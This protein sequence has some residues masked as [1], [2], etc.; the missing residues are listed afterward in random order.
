MG[1]NAKSSELLNVQ[2]N[3]SKLLTNTNNNL[4]K[5][6]ININNGLVNKID[7]IDN[8][9]NECT[10]E[11][12]Y[13]TLVTHT[14]VKGPWE[15]GGIKVIAHN[16]NH[17]PSHPANGFVIEYLGRKVVLSGD[18]SYGGVDIELTDEEIKQNKHF[19]ILEEVGKNCDLL[20]H[21]AQSYNG[22]QAVI[23]NI[24]QQASV[25]YTVDSE[26]YNRIQSQASVLED[27]FSYHTSPKQV[28][29]VARLLGAKSL[30][31]NHLVPFPPSSMLEVGLFDNPVK[32]EYTGNYIK[33]EDFGSLIRLEGNS[34]SEPIN[35]DKLKPGLNTQNRPQASDL[36]KNAMDVAIIGKSGPLIGAGD[37]SLSCTVVIAG[38][39]AL[40]ID[41]GSGSLTNTT[42]P[43]TSLGSIFYD[44]KISILITHYHSDH[45]TGLAD[46]NLTHWVTGAKEPLTVFGGPGIQDLV[47]GTNKMMYI[48][49]VI[50]K[51]HHPVIETG[52]DVYKIISSIIVEPG[53][54]NKS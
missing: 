13:T 34:S 9:V 49:Y 7:K 50:R 48:D 33:T 19:K 6:L 43:Y 4:S 2:D 54:N 12:D 8:C 31:L 29:Q 5:L 16:C 35:Y 3:L 53:T 52:Y 17:D 10:C 27:T 36:G 46:W 37:V 32:K 22:T 11:E 42:N 25:N 14:V 44:K 30:T 1:G 23:S 24:K 28:G 39:Y 47:N 26:P 15:E 38:D 45:I 41:C 40:I 21:E 18:C 20:V 51:E